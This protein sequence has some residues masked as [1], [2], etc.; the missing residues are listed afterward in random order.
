MKNRMEQL[1]RRWCEKAEDEEILRQLK[2]LE[3]E[4]D[5]LEDAFRADI[6]FGTAG[7]R[8]VMEPGTNRINIYT[9]GRAS[10]GLA[11]Y[12]N[13]TAGEQRPAVAISYDSRHRSRLFSREAASVFA[14]N[15]IE[16]WIYSEL[17]PT[18]CLSFAVRR[19]SCAAGVMVT[20]SHN[21]S[22]YNG[23]KVYGPDGCQI[24]SAA[25]DAIQE[26]ILHTD[27]FDDVHR[28]PYE[29]GVNAGLIHTISDEIVTEYIEAVKGESLLDEQDELSRDVAVVYTPLNGTGLVP[30]LR[31][32]EESGYTRLS[33]VE[34]QSAPDGSFATCPLPN[35]ENR[36]ALELAIRDAEKTGADLVMATDPDCDRIGIA[37]RDDRGEFALLTGN[38]TGILL[39]DYIC[40]LRLQKGSMPEDPVMVKTIVTTDIAERTAAGYGVRTEN[41]LTGFKYIGDVIAGLEQEGK[42]DSYLLGF[43]ESYGYLTGTYVRDKDAV[44]AALMICDMFAWHR[45]RGRSLLQRLDQIYEMH[46]FC[47]NRVASFRFEGGEG[48][49]RMQNL[50]ES[51]RDGIPS[52][53]GFTVEECTDYLQGIGNLPKSNVIRFRMASD[54][55][56]IARP[57]GTEPKLKFY[58]SAYARSKEEA[59]E[60]TD[61]ILRDV[62]AM[63]GNVI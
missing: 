19:L 50:M 10:Q 1:Y 29:E 25:A 57:S 8:G 36:E 44:N 42:E 39:L 45:S 56:L 49:R 5:R 3:Q 15:G 22:E 41:V 63:V 51:L 11:D 23:Y 54:T 18:P 37:V 6:S 58:L 38:E 16:V 28:M 7:L 32:L 21:S 59:R 13:A 31:T 26:A 48:E 12:L 34:E 17:M 20:A 55:I 24:T 33:V 61:S 40:T 46:G 4:P 9:V 52:I 30:V 47:L 60:K 14:A 62:E 53:G 35:P 2:E 43:E 27:L